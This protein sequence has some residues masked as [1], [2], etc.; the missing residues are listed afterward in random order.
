MKLQP[1]RNGGILPRPAALPLLLLMLLATACGIVDIGIGSDDSGNG[2]PV[3]RETRAAPTPD[4]PATIAAAVQKAVAQTETPPAPADTPSTD[5]LPA[6]SRPAATPAADLRATIAAALTAPTDTTPATPAPPSAPTYAPTSRPTPTPV[7]APTPSLLANCPNAGWLDYAGPDAAASILALPWVADGVAGAEC[8]AV[9]ELGYLADYPPLLR[10]LLSRPWV[11][12]GI[13]QLERAVID[14]TEDIAGHDP[15]LAEQ[16]A[17]LPWLADGVTQPE[18]SAVERLYGIT[19]R[20][21]AL[22]GDLVS[23]SWFRD[24]V[25]QTEDAAIESLYSIADNDVALAGQILTL[26]WLA[27]GVTQV[28]ESVLS[29]LGYLTDTDATLAGQ[30]LTLSW[31]ADGVTQVEE[32]VLSNL[33][34][35]ADDDAALAGQLAALPWFAD[36]VDAAEDP[37]VDTIAAIADDDTALAA[38]IVSLPWLADGISPTEASAIASLYYIAYDDAPLAAAVAALPWFADGIAAAENSV[39]DNLGYLMDADAALTRRI[40]GMPFLAAL[41]PADVVAIA[42]LSDL[43]HFEA[44]VFRQVMSHPTLRGGITDD[45]AGI[46]AVLAG[47]GDANPALIDVLLNPQR[48]TVERR[49]IDL[50]RSGSVDLAVIRTRPGARRSIDLLEHSVRSAEGFMEEP[51]PIGYI[52]LL[53]ENAV[54]GYSD[55]TN[56]GTH[57]AALPDYDVDDGGDDAQF[58]GHLIAHEVAHYYW[59]H[60]VDWVDEGAADLMASISENAR[61]GAPVAVTNPPCAAVSSIAELERLNPD[62]YADAFDCNYALGERFFLTLYRSIGDADFRQGFRRLYRMAQVEDDADDYA[63]TAVGIGHI[64]EAFQG[65]AAALSEAITLWYD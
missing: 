27:D 19:Y 52:A 2:N 29:D 49:R 55:G 26:P 10:I 15:A 57:I 32:S 45:W 62:A 7:P 56:F 11:A 16:L 50:P 18:P 51:L 42:S 54:A 40:I 8:A 25:T 44:P 48:V 28:E 36:G 6:A 31:L 34:Y 39:V 12:D 64:K 41:A 38:Q 33:A 4:L 23:L 24:D 59:R 1:N 53:F 61:A 58:A 22:A 47:V 35:L 14:R 20:D 5:T 37:V 65:N 13:N 21:T 60:G 43:A 63:G 9:R 46:V 3:S 17:N 30:I